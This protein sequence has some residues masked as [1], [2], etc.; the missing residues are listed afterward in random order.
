MHA[1]L[2]TLGTIVLVVA[3]QTVLGAL[4]PASWRSPAVR[5]RFAVVT[6]LLLASASWVMAAA[7]L[8]R[9]DHLG[10]ATPHDATVVDIG[11]AVIG[12]VMGGFALAAFTHDGTSNR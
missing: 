6:F 11:F 2:S 3:L 7:I 1:I 4:L 5:R 8:F 12:L 10:A 9:T